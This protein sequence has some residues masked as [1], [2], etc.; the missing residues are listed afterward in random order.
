M[1]RKRYSRKRASK[2]RKHAFLIAVVFFFAVALGIFRTFGWLT[3]PLHASQNE[4]I[5]YEHNWNGSER[6]NILLLGDPVILLAHYPKTGQFTALEIPSKTVFPVGSGY[7]DYRLEAIYPLGELEAKHEGVLLTAKVLNNY[8]GIPV[9][10]YIG[11]PSIGDIN[12]VDFF[13]KQ[14]HN[15]LWWGI[16]GFGWL[17]EVESNLGSVDLMRIVWS[18][19][20]TRF[21]KL[22]VF[23]LSAEQGLEKRE[24]QD[25]SIE[26]IPKQ[27]AIDQLLR[28]Y[29]QDED[30]MREGMRVVVKNATLHPGLGSIVSRRLRNLGV[31]I[32]AVENS[33]RWL[34]TTAIEGK[35]G[36][37]LRRIEQ[38]LGKQCI[39]SV[40]NDQPCDSGATGYNSDSKMS[41]A[42]PRGDIIVEVG[43]EEWIRLN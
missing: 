40:L 8:L 43:E 39:K 3:V 16:R 35:P 36:Y 19:A 7:G 9:D 15:P 26:L 6:L 32:V 13:R 38:L 33:D 28:T 23:S 4:T 18:L 41:N 24:R 37:T 2:I 34:T 10:G 21:D 42:D 27:A 22:Q 25:G 17:N 11:W 31:Q 20:W 14:V 5:F 30:I 12:V 1:P 29:F